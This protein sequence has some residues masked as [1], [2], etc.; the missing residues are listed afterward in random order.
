MS[1]AGNSRAGLDSR[2]IQGPFA[3]RSDVSGIEELARSIQENGLLHPIIVRGKNDYFEII[4]DF[5]RYNACK[6]LGW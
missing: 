5:R 6:L 3:V 4:A 1:T 2:A